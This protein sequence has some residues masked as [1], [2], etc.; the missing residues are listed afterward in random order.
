MDSGLTDGFRT[1]DLVGTDGHTGNMCSG[2]I[3]HS[4]QWAADSAADVEHF[5]TWLELHFQGEIR[6][7]P[8]QR[9]G[10]RFRRES[11]GKMKTSA[12]SVQIGR[13]HV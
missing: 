8:L 7:V 10:Q 5:V 9:L 1:L 2:K 13:A 12:P 3:G 11:I 4:S 6:F